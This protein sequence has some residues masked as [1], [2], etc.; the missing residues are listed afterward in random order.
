MTYEVMTYNV[1]T[2][3]IITYDV[4]TCAHKTEKTTFSCKDDW[5]KC[6]HVYWSGAKIKTVPDPSLHNLSCACF[7]SKSYLTLIVDTKSIS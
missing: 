3:D 2:Y 5:G 4:K 1:M 6:L 7:L